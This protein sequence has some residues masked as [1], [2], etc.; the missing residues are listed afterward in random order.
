MRGS[1]YAHCL[2]W[3][4]D[5]PKLDTN[6]DEEVCAFIDEYIATV[7]PEMS[8]QN[9]HSIELIK[10][11]QKHMHADYCQHN[12]LCRFAFQKAPSTHTIIFQQSHC[13][14]GGDM[15]TDAKKVLEAVQ[16]IIATTDTNDPSLSLDNLLAANGL[17]VDIYIWM[18]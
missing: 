12:N 3:V 15:V 17:D 16:H 6:S 2:L 4:K 13:P 11:L 10:N 7:L 5:A 8:Q 1:L 14:D 9:A 18:H